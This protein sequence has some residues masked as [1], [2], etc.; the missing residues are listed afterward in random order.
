MHF[1]Q[2]GDFPSSP[3]RH[4]GHFFFS[5]WYAMQMAQ[6]IPQGAI[7]FACILS[8]TIFYHPCAGIHFL[9]VLAGFSLP[10]YLT[11]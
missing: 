9:S 1:R 2:D 7:K 4:P 11:V 8:R 3:P 10:L 6:F 5:R